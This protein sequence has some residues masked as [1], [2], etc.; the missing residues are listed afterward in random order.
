MGENSGFSGG[1]EGCDDAELL[2]NYKK[3]S[4]VLV[5]GHMF[6]FNECSSL[7]YAVRSRTLK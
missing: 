5:F 2:G 7:T 6:G 1:D 3:L 4:L